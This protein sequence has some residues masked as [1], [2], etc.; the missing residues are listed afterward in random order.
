MRLCHIVP[1]VVAIAVSMAQ[2]SDGQ[3]FRRRPRAHAHYAQHVVTRPAK[4]Y[5]NHALLRLIKDQQRLHVGDSWGQYDYQ[6]FDFVDHQ[7]FLQS[8]PADMTRHLRKDEQFLDLVVQIKKMQAPEREAL[9][10]Q[11]L[12]TFRPTWAENGRI[13][14]DGQT[15]AGQHAERLVAQMIVD[16]VKSLLTNPNR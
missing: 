6:C 3:I 7:R 1:L 8:V 14:R 5:K 9:L 12:R 10:R 11:A 16:L 13:S 2:T 15:V 4:T